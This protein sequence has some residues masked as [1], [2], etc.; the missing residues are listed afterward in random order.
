MNTFTA[1]LAYF[2]FIFTWISGVVL[3]KGAWLKVAA[4]FCP[5]YAWYLIIERVLIMAGIA[6]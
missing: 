3:A 5:F 4:I 2:L 1:M 6:T